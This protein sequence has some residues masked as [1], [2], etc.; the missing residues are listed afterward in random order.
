[1]IQGRDSL[2]VSCG[3][4]L[5]CQFL[6]RWAAL[7]CL[8]R[9]TLTSS[10]PSWKDRMSF[11]RSFYAITCHSAYKE[12]WLALLQAERVFT[13]CQEA[14]RKPQIIS[15]SEVAASVICG[16]TQRSAEHPVTPMS[17]GWLPRQ[18]GGKYAGNSRKETWERAWIQRIGLVKSPKPNS[19]A[20]YKGKSDPQKI[21][22]WVFGLIQATGCWDA[23]SRPFCTNCVDFEKN[24]FYLFICLL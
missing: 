20:C 5:T 7:W 13:Y 10:L 9:Q 11:R 4:S 1:M 24:L 21:C 17:P 23:A 16:L 8:K 12:L 15:F 19:P 2:S 14:L 6:P 3:Q 22:N 18:P